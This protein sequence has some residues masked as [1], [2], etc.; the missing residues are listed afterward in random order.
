MRDDLGKYY[1]RVALLHYIG[2]KGTP[3]ILLVYKSVIGFSK[4]LVFLSCFYCWGIV[5]FFPFNKRRKLRFDVSVVI[6]GKI[7]IQTC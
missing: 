1:L 2:L 4:D 6:L 7:E 3:L 5:P